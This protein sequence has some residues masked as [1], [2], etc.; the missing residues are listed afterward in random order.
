MSIKSDASDVELTGHLFQ[1]ISSQQIGSKAHSKFKE[2]G[3][4]FLIQNLQIQ[5]P[6]DEERDCTLRLV[7][8]SMCECNFSICQEIRK[9]IELIFVQKNP[10]DSYVSQI[11][12]EVLAKTHHLCRAKYV[13]TCPHYSTLRRLLEIPEVCCN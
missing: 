2:N 3:L 7:L 12:K 5:F 9:V 4:S 6:S 1:N 10:F 8:I 11:V 13:Y